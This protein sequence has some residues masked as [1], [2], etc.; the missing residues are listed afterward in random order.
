MR[1]PAQHSAT[2]SD[3]RPAASSDA[4]QPGPDGGAVSPAIGPLPPIYVPRPPSQAST[5]EP[6]RRPTARVARR[7]GDWVIRHLPPHHERPEL[8]NID[9]YG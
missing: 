6:L 1:K 5:P 4:T 9:H 7:A 2:A 3:E 8:V